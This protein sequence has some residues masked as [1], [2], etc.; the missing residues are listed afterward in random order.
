M[1]DDTYNDA[2]LLLDE[3][4]EQESKWKIKISDKTSQIETLKRD[5]AY[6]QRTFHD[7]Q[8]KYNTDMQRSKD[9]MN[10][11]QRK[12]DDLLKAYATELSRSRDRMDECVAQSG[13]HT[14]TNMEGLKQAIVEN[15]QHYNMK[16]KL[17]QEEKKRERVGG[18]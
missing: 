10:D 5:K 6:V 13:I 14:I 9:Q 11:L 3:M 4:K 17:E 2:K 7:L 18:S 12:F 1:A 16:Y 15:H 8:T